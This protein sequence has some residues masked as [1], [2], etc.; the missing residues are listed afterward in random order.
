M[1]V[2][3]FDCRSTARTK[4]TVVCF[5]ALK[6]ESDWMEENASICGMCCVHNW[7]SARLQKMGKY[8]SSECICICIYMH[9]NLRTVWLPFVASHSHPDLEAWARRSSKESIQLTNLQHP[10]T[11]WPF[12]FY[13]VQFRNWC[14]L[15]KIKGRFLKHEWFLFHC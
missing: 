4:T 13:H 8:A 14:L 5:S 2:E 6:I 9:Q 1:F 7:C 12:V 15:S 3:N 10:S 11:N